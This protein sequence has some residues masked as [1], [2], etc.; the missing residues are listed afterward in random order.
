[1]VCLYLQV[2]GSELGKAALDVGDWIRSGCILWVVEEGRTMQKSRSRSVQ[3]MQDNTVYST[4]M[5][6]SLDGDW[7]REEKKI[8]VNGG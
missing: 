4:R 2:Q 3:H 8:H 1:L 6:F 7:K 5:R